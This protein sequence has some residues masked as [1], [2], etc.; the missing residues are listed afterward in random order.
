MADVEEYTTQDWRR[1]AESLRTEERTVRLDDLLD[2]LVLALTAF[3]EGDEYKRL[4][5]HP[6]TD[7]SGLPMQM[8]YRSRTE[9]VE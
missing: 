6:P 7:A 1:L 8:V 3:A 5:P 2:A 4:P 9:L